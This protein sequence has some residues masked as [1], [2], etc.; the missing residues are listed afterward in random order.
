MTFETFSIHQIFLLSN[1]WKVA[2]LVHE[3][4][5]SFVP[6]KPGAS[7]WKVQAGGRA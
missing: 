5:H 1:F 7:L 4:I 3:F 6:N 2:S